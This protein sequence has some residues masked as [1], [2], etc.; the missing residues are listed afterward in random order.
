MNDD[1]TII[2]LSIRYWVLWAVWCGIVGFISSSQ[3]WTH[4]I[5]SQDGNL[6]SMHYGLKLSV[7][8]YTATDLFSSAFWTWTKILSSRGNNSILGS[9]RCFFMISRRLALFRRLS[10]VTPDKNCLF[11]ITYNL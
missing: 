8:F 2:F 6:F 4:I 11:L 7:I 10:F 5:I 3:L 1:I 9:S